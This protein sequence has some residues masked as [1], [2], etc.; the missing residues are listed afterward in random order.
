MYKIPYKIGYNFIPLTIVLKIYITFAFQ[1]MF[2]LKQR[3]L[4]GK[5]LLRNYLKMLE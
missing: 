5:I 1:L 4:L 2:S 3:Q